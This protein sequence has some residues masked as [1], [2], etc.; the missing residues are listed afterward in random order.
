MADSNKTEQ[1]TPRHRQKARERGQVIRSR[2]LTSAVVMF[3]VAGAISNV[4][5]QGARHWT[6]FFRN[7]LDHANTGTIEAS[8]PLLF[9]TSI[10]AFRW[11]VPILS[12]VLGASLIVGYAQG[13]FVF[14]PEALSIKPERFSPANKLS[15]IFS[16]TGLSTTLKSLIPFG[17]I[18]WIAYSCVSSH[19][20][21]ILVSCYPCSRR[22]FGRAV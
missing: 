17:G 11:I 16:V 12:S 21:P 9:W 10:E 4:A 15:N 20:Q 7:A 19:W 14:A 5:Q 22:S 2:E 18:C 3:A 6:D 1:A 13:G 8:G